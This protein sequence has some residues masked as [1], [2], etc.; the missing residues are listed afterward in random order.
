MSIVTFWNDERDQTGKTLT[1]V[2]VATRMAIERNYKILLISTCFQDPTI[3]NCFWVDDAQRTLKLFGVKNNNIAVENG[4]EG[5]I[6]LIS[7]KKLTPNV[8]TDYTRVIFKDRLEIINGY[9]G[10]K[11]VTRDTNFMEYE[12]IQK[13]YSELIK[14]ASQYYDMVLVD[15][16]KEIPEETRKEILEI[17]NL[18]VYVMSQKKCSLDRYLERKQKIQKSENLKTLPV[19]GRY[20]NSTKYNLKNISKYLQE[21]KG[22]N[23]IPYNTQLFEAAEET[24]VVDLFFRLS[25]IRDTADHNYIFMKELRS[26]S[27]KIIEKLKELQAG[28]R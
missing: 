17:S 19:I 7:A 20:M 13:Y 22:L 11:D 27:D 15:L 5:I 1:A 2:S 12:K 26:L 9:F 4:I 18:N 14:V 8:I 3:K 16:D 23:V 6:K 21:K 28:M 10:A 24:G 25:K